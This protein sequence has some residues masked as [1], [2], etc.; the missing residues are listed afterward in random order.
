M[1]YENEIKLEAI[2]DITTK[3]DLEYLETYT[4]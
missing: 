3:Q 1:S 4:N 2:N